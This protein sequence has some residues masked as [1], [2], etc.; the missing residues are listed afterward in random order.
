MVP[1]ATQTRFK[2]RRMWS[3]LFFVML[4]LSVLIMWKSARTAQTMSVA[5]ALEPQ[6]EQ[7]QPG[8]KIKIVAEI[9]G[10]P[11]SG[12]FCGKLLQ[13]KTEQIYVRTKSQVSLHS[14]SQTKVVMGKDSD[15]HDGA[16]VHVTGTVRADHS[17]YL[18]QFVILTGYVQVHV[19]VQ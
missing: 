8:S 7:A 9:E 12:E 1:T 19:Q 6:V 17:L 14:T 3:V 16:I 11:Q 4:T 2:Y 5:A 10:S 18:E 13:K 15:L